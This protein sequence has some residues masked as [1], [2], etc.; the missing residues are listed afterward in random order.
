MNFVKQLNIR[1]IFLAL[2]VPLSL[3]SLLSGC[4]A[5]PHPRME[6]PIEEVVEPIT[7]F[8]LERSRPK[9]LEEIAGGIQ[10]IE[11]HP[12]GP[13]EQPP[14]PTF[15][16]DRKGKL[17]AELFIGERHVWIGLDQMSPYLIYSTQSALEHAAAAVGLKLDKRL[18]TTQLARLIRGNSENSTFY[19]LQDE[20][21][22]KVID[23]L[24]ESYTESELWAL[25][26]NLLRYAP[27]AYGP[28]MAAQIYFS[29]S[30]ADLTL[31]EATFLTG[32]LAGRTP[33]DP[34]LDFAETIQRRG[35]LIEAL[36]QKEFV[37]EDEARE[38]NRRL[39]PLQENIAEIKETLAPQFVQYV[40]DM[41]DEQLEPGRTIRTGWH[42]YTTLDLE[43]QLLGERIMTS[44]LANL[45]AR[46][47]T[48]DSSLLVMQPRT[49]EIL[50][51]IDSIYRDQSSIELKSASRTEEEF[52]DVDSDNQVL[53]PHQPGSVIIPLIYAAAIEENLI[54][55]ATVLWD[56]PARF[57]W[58][59]TQ[60]YIPFS[61]DLEFQG[62]MSA[63]SALIEGALVPAVKLIDRMGVDQLRHTTE[64]LGMSQLIDEDITVAVNLPLRGGQASLLELTGAYN[65]LA[66]GGEYKV[67][68]PVRRILDARG[69]PVRLPKSE[70]ELPEGVSPQTAF[71]VTD[72]L[73]RPL[74]PDLVAATPSDV[75]LSPLA[76]RSAVYVEG[77]SSD[78]LN[79][80]TTGYTPHM[81]VG[82][83]LGETVNHTKV[84]TANSSYTTQVW[85]EFV[86][87]TLSDPDLRRT[88]QLNSDDEDIWSFEP[89]EG[90]ENLPECPP[91]V[92]CRSGSE[93]F[94]TAWLEKMEMNG[95]PLGDSVVRATSKEAFI[96]WQGYKQ[97]AG[98]CQDGGEGGRG[99]MQMFLSLPELP[100]PQGPKAHLPVPPIFQPTL[101]QEH[102]EILK[103]SMGY[104][105]PVDFGSCSRL[106]RFVYSA[107]RTEWE[108]QRDDRPV[109][110]EQAG[111]EDGFNPSRPAGQWP[112]PSA[113]PSVYAPP[114]SVLPSPYRL[115]QIRATEP[116]DV[117]KEVLDSITESTGISFETTQIVTDT[118]ITGTIETIENIVVA[119]PTPSISQEIPATNTPVSAATPVVT[120]TDSRGAFSI[121]M[122]QRGTPTPLPES[123]IPR[124]PGSIRP[125]NLATP[126]P[127]PINTP[128]PTPASAEDGVPVDGDV[129]GEDATPVVDGTPTPPSGDLVEGVPTDEVPLEVIV[130][131]L[132]PT[133]EGQIVTAEPTPEDGTLTPTRIPIEVTIPPVTPTPTGT[134]TPEAI[135]GAE[136]TE[137]GSLDGADGAD[138][139]DVADVADDGGTDPQPEGDVV[140][141]T[142]DVGDGGTFKENYLVADQYPYSS[143]AG[144]QV[145]GVVIDANTNPLP[146]VRLNYVDQWGNELSEVTGGGFSDYGLFDFSISVETGH[147][148]YIT[149][150]N[151]AGN[152]V[153]NT[154]VIDH[155]Q[156]ENVGYLCHYLVFRRIN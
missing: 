68:S 50:V 75:E 98:F 53:A 125:F 61:S 156:A 42:I 114:P 25:Y 66:N 107:M 102:L 64:Q 112:L 106:E 11:R 13:I 84:N 130:F 136:D 100:R 83:W 87:E 41:I 133:Q 29:K 76:K 51:M 74:N 34:V 17:L 28:E 70:D 18:L 154:A 9:K 99:V 89:P 71:L 6:E 121:A 97:L 15:I 149:I 43:M 72:M 27:N 40:L 127:I 146:G 67:A 31:G 49:A 151:D 85:R 129:A 92:Q 120:P 141:D 10:L 62:A 86:Q 32:L 124:P 140:V 150:V 46:R 96:D 82:I 115:W 56:L 36:V 69:E 26:I 95:G 131:T 145:V 93:Y 152:P 65:T 58:D 135:V 57:A 52:Q 111:S 47:N 59:D 8:S 122:S 4:G 155:Q 21:N 142:A 94:S 73:M 30:A 132:T 119:I 144:E 139:A 37:T 5:P 118:V 44:K 147:Q 22:Q 143:C 105:R 138:G 16:Y 54:S 109:I 38:V 79:Y 2:I 78:H 103:W 55:P 134:L 88:L 60:W 91:Y 80:W 63:R 3:I 104:S 19:V 113:Y 24:E 1:L 12:E 23:E 33:L 128:S 14:Q 81:A 137:E 126:T 7:N 35:L 90:V 148:I 45:Q 110:V 48:I 153:S 108:I 117:P 101:P 20:I 123:G 39:M 116:A 77:V